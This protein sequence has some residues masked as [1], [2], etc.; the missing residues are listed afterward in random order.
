MKDLE[1]LINQG[2]RPSRLELGQLF[3][4][5][6][7]D[8]LAARI[9]GRVDE[10]SQASTWLEGLAQA[11]DEV[12]PF[13]AELL[14][15]RA[16]R[17][18]E[19]EQRQAERE[20]TRTQ[21]PA[22]SAWWRRFLPLTAMAAAAALAVVIVLPDPN[23]RERH[24]VP[25]GA[26]RAKGL[27]SLGFYVLRDEQVH[28]GSEDEVHWAG[29]RIQF[30]YRTV[31]WE[32]LVVLSLDGRGELNLYYPAEG[33]APVDVIPGERR[34]LDGSIILDDA[35]DFELILAYF[36]HDSVATVVDEVHA[37]HEEEGREGLLLLAE[38]YPDVDAIFLR[39]GERSPGAGSP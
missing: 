5:E 33:D 17:I 11:R 16:F 26:E 18:Q 9:R 4:G 30:S 14:R 13:D 12:A 38:D 7:D 10:R 21:A 19:E 20:A 24:V 22:R 29:D 6:L 28:P 15:K 25:P 3:T 2:E 35:P 1:K 36:G 32:S 37:I 39:K 27:G 8:D 31:G 34:M 23:A